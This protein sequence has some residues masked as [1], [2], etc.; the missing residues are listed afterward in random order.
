MVDCS[1]IDSNGW[2]CASNKH[3]NS[4]FEQTL[5]E[6][7]LAD[8]GA[9]YA[10]LEFCSDLT[11][12]KDAHTT[13]IINFDDGMIIDAD[14]SFANSISQWPGLIIQDAPQKQYPLMN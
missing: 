4:S 8:L 14:L 1:R 7:A 9:A 12:R 6:V 10:A 11:L 13:G 5:I 3:F 2:G